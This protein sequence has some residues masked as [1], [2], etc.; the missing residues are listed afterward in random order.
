MQFSD[1]L[2]SHPLYTKCQLD[3]P[4]GLNN[5]HN[6]SWPAIKAFC[7]RCNSIQTFVHF[8]LSPDSTSYIHPQGGP[9]EYA[10]IEFI[11]VCA[12]CRGTKGPVHDFDKSYLYY[13]VRFQD[14][15][16]AIKVGQYPPPDISIGKELER[17]LDK[18][19][20]DYKKG[21]ICELHGYGIGAYAYYRRI[22]EQAI[23]KLLNRIHDLL[24]EK[25][26]L[27]YEEALRQTQKNSPAKDK[28]AL[29]KDLLPSSL[30]PNKMNPLAILHETLSE[31]LHEKSDE[32]CLAA[33][34]DIREILVTLVEKLDTIQDALDSDRSFTQSMKRL[35]DKKSK[36]KKR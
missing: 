16:T 20:D 24:D 29:V 6:Y 1:F 12:A 19:T 5:L 10:V 8:P 26:K 35:L 25:E 34:T 15:S 21:R 36:K 23:D 27:I 9:R 32:E 22:V 11:Y 4:L 3:S 2:T 17:V 18:H 13:L 33:A 30:R 28:I 14:E 31:G 7:P